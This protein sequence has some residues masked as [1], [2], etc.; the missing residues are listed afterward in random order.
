MANVRGEL[1]IEGKGHTTPINALIDGTVLIVT[2]NRYPCTHTEVRR[3]GIY[4]SNVCTRFT[5]YVCLRVSLYH[6]LPLTPKL[7]VTE[8]LRHQ[9]SMQGSVPATPHKRLRYE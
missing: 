7:V 1:N 8:L 3:R 6:Q 5:M 9:E 2:K 4:E